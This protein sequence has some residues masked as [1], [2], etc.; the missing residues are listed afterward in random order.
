MEEIKVIAS[1]EEN[2]QNQVTKYSVTELRQILDSFE[3]DHTPA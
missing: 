2:S 1:E 3:A